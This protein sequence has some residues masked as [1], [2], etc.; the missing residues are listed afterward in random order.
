MVAY[1]DSEWGAPT[2]DDR[3]LLELLVLEGAQAG[4]SWRT[5]L[6]RRDGYRR[7]FAGFDPQHVAAMGPDETAALLSDPGIV[8]NR[9]KVA[10]AVRNAGAL[11]DVAA[12][13]GSF[14]AYLW[15]AVDGTPVVGG[16]S[17]A[18]EVPVTTPL[19]DSLSKDLRRRGFNFVGPT[20]VYSL[21]Q[22]AGL[23]MDHL[24]GCFRYPELLPP[25][26]V[27]GPKG[28]AS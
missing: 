7:A 10:S 23:V 20:I 4:L 28:G 21:L 17:D 19:A 11:L 9:A 8:R 2:T 14:G 15:S 25:R 13:F 16:W 26:P 22:A 5:V 24:T 18:G 12:T 1:H 27:N 3:E 6:H